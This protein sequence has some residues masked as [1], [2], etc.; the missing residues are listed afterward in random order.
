ML[1]GIKFLEND[2]EKLQGKLL[3]SAHGGD[4]EGTA[5]TLLKMGGIYQKLGSA[6]KAF[7]S[8]ENAKKL[9]KKCRNPKGEALSILN[10][11]KIHEKKGKYRNAQKMYKEAAEKFKKLNDI[12]NQATSLYH[13]ARILEKQGKFEDALNTYKEYHRLS[14]LTDDKTKLLA[15]Y[16]KIKTIEENL[17]T[18]PS[19]YHWLL[20][21]GYIIGLSIAELSTSYVSIPTGLGVHAFILFVLFL[22]SSLAPN[23]KFRKLLN[24]MMV[25]PLIRIIGLSMPI[26]KIPQLYWFII[27]AIPLFAAS[28]TLMKIQ[29]LGRKDVGL[30]LNR[31]ILQLLIALTGIPLGYIE[32]KIL[33]PQALIPALTLQYLLLGSIVML[34][35]TGLAEELIFRGIIQKNSEELFGAAI[36]LLYTA[37]LFTMFHVGWK[38]NRD[39]IFV[40]LVAIFYG[41]TYHKTRSIIGITFSHGLSNTI[42][43]LIMPFLF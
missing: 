32:F 37:L 24:S 41:Y 17:S 18:K 29:D 15:S 27:I 43:F 16:A 30:T 23:E 22:H 19:R 13:K 5:N 34:L 9:Y 11:G 26:M 28:Y 31:P 6:D 4:L 42:L 3:K 21:I 35:G 8:Y 14:S 38:S 20:F 12:K 33:H 2:L 7:E 10:I 40:F 39:L 36:G 25:L 1:G